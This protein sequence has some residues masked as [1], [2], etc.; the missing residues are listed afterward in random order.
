MIFSMSL[1]FGVI[2]ALCGLALAVLLGIV[3][4]R[5][6]QAKLRSVEKPLGVQ[7]AAERA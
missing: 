7:K 4:Y 2:F 6:P 1:W 5:D 3:I